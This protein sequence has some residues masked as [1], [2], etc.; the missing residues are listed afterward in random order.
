VEIAPEDADR[1]GIE[2]GDWVAVTS[3]VARVELRARVHEQIRPGVLGLP[4]GGWGRVVGDLAGAPSR[5]LEARVDPATGQ[6]LAWETR[7]KVE[8]VG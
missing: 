6:W 2:D 4:L 5:L 1:L 8:R 7:A 3:K